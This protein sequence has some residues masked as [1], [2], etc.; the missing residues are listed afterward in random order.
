[1]EL[2]DRE[3]HLHAGE[4]SRAVELK[5]D[6][7]VSAGEARV[8]PTHIVVPRP[9]VVDV[10]VCEIVQAADAVRQLAQTLRHTEGQGNN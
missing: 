4:V 10:A 3:T 1:M 8:A 7:N 9:H 5:H 6:F 2:D